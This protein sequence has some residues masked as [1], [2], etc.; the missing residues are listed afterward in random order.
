MSSKFQEVREFGATATLL[1]AV[2]ATR[3]ASAATG[4]L[5]VFLHTFVKQHAFQTA[6]ES[7][8]PGCEVIAVGRI[9]DFE[10]VL[11][12]GVDAVLTLPVVLTA[13]K[14]QPNI[15]GS[16]VGRAEENY[17]LVAVG[18]APE[19]ERVATVG[20]LDVLG[21]EGTTSFVRSLL[22]ASPRVE[23]VVKL[24]DLVRLLQAQATD[25]VLLPSR[26]LPE[27]RV[28]SRLPL[29]QRELTR[30]VGLPAAAATSSTGQSILTAIRRMPLQ[31]AETFGVDAW[32]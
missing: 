6:L 24:E 10:R 11:A 19:P 17:S 4:K 14:L 3:K 21:R 23:R 9:I 2:L 30:R 25:A 28:T 18:A 13:F 20:A 7:A 27:M 15:Q 16:L 26:L 1:A 31:V 22:G 8:L 5:L 32:R 12:K 29:T